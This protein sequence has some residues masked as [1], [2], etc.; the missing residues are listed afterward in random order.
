[1]SIYNICQVLSTF[2]TD[3][4]NSSNMTK[5]NTISTAW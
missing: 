3:L 4:R 5:S 2:L 1:M